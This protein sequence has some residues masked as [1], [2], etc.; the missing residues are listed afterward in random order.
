MISSKIILTLHPCSCLTPMEITSNVLKLTATHVVIMLTIVWFTTPTN[1][2]LMTPT[3]QFHVFPTLLINSMILHLLNSVIS[4][5]MKRTTP[6]PI[7]NLFRSPTVNLTTRNNDRS[8]HSYIQKPSIR[9]MSLQLSML[10]FLWAPYSKIKQY[11]SP[12]PALNVHRYSEPV[13]TDTIYS[14]TPAIDNGATQ[15]IL[16]RLKDYGLWCL[17]HEDWQAICQHFRG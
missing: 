9:P 2:S 12:N 3:P 17:S 7:V 11:M 15:R 13:A 6:T 10:V 16:R 1:I 14:N 4:S 5:N 8:L